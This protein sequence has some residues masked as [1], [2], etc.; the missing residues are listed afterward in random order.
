M[1]LRDTPFR[2][3]QTPTLTVI[4][5]ENGGQFRQVPTNG[6]TLVTDP[7]PTWF[8]YSTGRWDADD[9]VVETQGFR[10]DTWLDNRGLPHTDA[11]RLIER[12]RRVSVG[13]MDLIL[14]VDDV[15]AYTRPW[16]V[17]V[18]L[19]FMPDTDLLEF[20]CENNKYKALPNE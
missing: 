20:I 18:G 10:E 1:M 13:R 17:T 12:F 6:R 9:F 11:L 16:S 5:L 4:L 2:I 15:K 3:V 19:E 14:T 8:G 7:Q